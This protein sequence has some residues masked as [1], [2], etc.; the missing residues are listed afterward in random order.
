MIQRNHCEQGGKSCSKEIATVIGF[1]VQSLI[2]AQLLAI[3]WAAAHQAPLSFTL[4][5]LHYLPEFGQTHV[6]WVSDVIKPSHPLLPPSPFVFNCFQNQS[7][8]QWADSSHQVAKVLLELQHQFFQ[9]IFRVDF[10]YEWLAWSPFCPMDSQKSSPAPQFE[11]INSLALT[12]LYDPTPT[13]V[14][15][16]WKIVAVTIWTFVNKVMSLFFNMLS[17]FIGAFP[18]NKHL[19]ISWLQSLFKWFLEP[20]IIKS[21]ML[22]LFLLLFS[23]KW[24]DWLS[25]SCIF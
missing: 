3:P 17:T 13:S 11:S 12:F 10:L 18:R 6:H 14:H 4:S 7:L 8:F 20:E 23:K 5:Q 1:V 9:W 22:L 2:C 24:W 16:S 25:G 21:T 15:G 19:L